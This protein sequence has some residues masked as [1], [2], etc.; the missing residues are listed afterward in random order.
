VRSFLV[1][2]QLPGTLARWIETQGCRAEHVLT[3]QLAQSKDTPI[4]AY[5]A[6]TGAVIVSKDEDFAQMTLIRLEP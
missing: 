1:D 2:N 3:L 6:A 5:A 4:W